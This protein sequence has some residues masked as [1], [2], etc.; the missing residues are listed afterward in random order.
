VRRGWRSK[1]GLPA[2][3]DDDAGHW[4]GASVRRRPSL[5]SQLLILQLV[6]V[7]MVLIFVA[8]VSYA[9]AQASFRKVEGRRF[10]SVA[11]NTAGL[12]TL[13]EGLDSRE[14]REVLAARFAPIAEDASDQFGASY[15]VIA[16]ADRTILASTDPG[17]VGQT[18]DLNDSN[19]LEGRA[20][21]GVVNDAGA[22]LLVAHAPVIGEESLDTVGLVAVGD[23]LPGFWES[24][25]NSAPNLLTYL[26][27][28]S[29]LGIAGSLLLAQRVKRQTLGLEPREIAGLVEQ[30]EAM[31][32]GIKEGVVGLDPRQ[33]ITLI[34]DK[35]LEL[36]GLPA[37]SVGMTIGDLGVEGRLL[38]VLTGRT[39]GQDQ[40]V[41]LDERVL[42]LN[43]MPIA[44]KGRPIGSVTTLRDRTELVSLQRELDVTRHTTDTL[45]AQTHEFSNQLHTISGLVEL[46][47]YE[48]VIGYIRRLSRSQAQL[49]DEVT[50]R[51]RDPSVAAL[52]IAKASQAA[53]QGVQL[54][55]SERTRLDRVGEHLSA[56]L[57][58]VVGNL[59]DNALDAI[60]YAPNGWIEVEL[61]HEA[62]SVCV[63]ARDSG[64]GVAPELADEVFKHGFTTKAAET[65]GQRGFGLAL[66]RLV[67]TRRG[68]SVSVRNDHGAVFTARLPVADEV[69]SDGVPS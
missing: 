38:D 55:I 54:R 39:Q 18:L 69:V 57:T 47:E 52:L 42:I 49:N 58:T 21:E 62:G 14:L 3:R 44:S 11:E 28:A 25:R 10:L 5:A 8:A 60:G 68:G 32:H 13:Q 50:S 45:R 33:R 56:D 37:D 24:L 66:I 29:I 31:L 26:G 63:V 17:R 46:A 67:C 35:A 59:V 40:I 61:V 48:E 6:I 4:D 53:E 43:R 30:R 65:D 27:I 41:L 64:P 36:L 9:Q 7:V 1:L 20:W 23:S 34:N 51:V 22:T 12:G 2:A 15:V 16:A 19:V